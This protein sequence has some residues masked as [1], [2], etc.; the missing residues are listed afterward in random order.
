MSFLKSLACV[1]L[2]AVSL[3]VLAKDP[4]PS[5]PIKVVIPFPP[6]GAVDTFVRTMAPELASELGQPIVVDNRPG[7]GGQIG[8]AA[9]LGAPSDGYTLFVAEIGAYVI[10]PMI[11]K[12]ISYLPMR[13]FDNIT[14]LARAPM[15]MYSSSSGHLKSFAVLK[16]TIKLGKE[17]N[18]G[19]FG[20]GTA[21]HILGHA[22]GKSMAGSKLVHV[23]YKGAP[24]AFQAIM[25]NEIDLLFDAVPGTLNMVRNSKGIPLAVAAAQRTEFLPNVPTFAELGFANLKMDLWIGASVKKGTPPAIVNTLNT[26]IEKVLGQPAVW[27]RYA[28]FGYSRSPMS[29][30]Q[31]QAYIEAET[32]RYRP[33]VVDTGVTVD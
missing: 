8:A 26:A 31:F 3:A 18:Y 17:L 16:D 5:K 30:A 6:G 10:N 19:S 33:L 2:S 24:P 11:Y 1:A 27:K 21:P 14:M 29:P 7:G 20:P 4:Y 13:D 28:D 22:M 9:V 23:P 15:V 25:S 12:S 32:L